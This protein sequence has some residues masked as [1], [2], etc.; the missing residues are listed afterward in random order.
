MIESI[1][2]SEKKPGVGLVPVYHATRPELLPA[3]LNGELLP[4]HETALI[5]FPGDNHEQVNFK[6]ELKYLNSLFDE[7]A[8][9]LQPPF[10]RASSIFARVTPE[11][12]C[13]TGDP[14]LKVII[15]P[16]K[17]LVADQNSFDIAFEQYRYGFMD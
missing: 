3:I 7:V 12:T 4:M 16:D 10:Q 8:R 17:V 5:V 6:R 15:N 1:G 2:I 11:E 13:A 14:V 9:W